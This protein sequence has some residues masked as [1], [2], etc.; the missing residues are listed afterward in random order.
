MK[1]K[2]SCL[3]TVWSLAITFWFTANIWRSKVRSFS[4]GPDPIGSPSDWRTFSNPTK[5]SLSFSKRRRRFHREITRLQLVSRIDEK[6][7][8]GSCLMWSRLIWITWSMWW[9]FLRS[10]Y[11]ARLIFEQSANQKVCSV[12]QFLLVQNR[13]Y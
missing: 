8:S 11:N 5:T 1:A 2:S 3:W 10:R 13:S 4:S 7:C 6:L 9:I 12:N